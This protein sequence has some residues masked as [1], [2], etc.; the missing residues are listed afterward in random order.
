MSAWPRE[1]CPEC[2]SDGIPQ[3]KYRLEPAGVDY[4]GCAYNSVGFMRTICPDC[5]F[6]TETWARHEHERWEKQ[7]MLLKERRKRAKQLFEAGHSFRG[8]LT[9]TWNWIRE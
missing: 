5:G 9:T 3:N 8:C 2:D 7:Q 4:D 1:L 6:Y